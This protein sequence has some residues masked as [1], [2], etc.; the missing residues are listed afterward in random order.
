MSE[1]KISKDITQFL[2]PKTTTRSAGFNEDATPSSSRYVHDESQT[3]DFDLSSFNFDL[4]NCTTMSQCSKCN[5]MVRFNYLE[6]HADFHVAED[7]QKD[8]DR[9][10]RDEVIKK[11]KSTGT[12]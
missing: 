8:L 5:K 9:Q 7:I 3:S 6:E 11:R 10:E 12:S 1:P 4:E 2:T